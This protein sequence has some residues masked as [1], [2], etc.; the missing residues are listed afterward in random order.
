MC[1]A[2]RQ[3]SSWARIKLSKKLYPKYPSG[4]LKSSRAISSFT[5][6]LSSILNKLWRDQ[7]C[8]CNALYFSLVVQFSMTIATLSRGQLDY[9]ITI[10]L[11]CQYLF[12]IFFTFFKKSFL[13]WFLVFPTALFLAGRNFIIPL[14]P[15]Y[16]KQFWRFLSFWAFWP[17]N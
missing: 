17:K 8:T 11:I 6:C 13:M 9:S 4:Y 10:T 3:R 16:V 7:Y 15:P 2:R 5:F 1:Y 14:K 12:S